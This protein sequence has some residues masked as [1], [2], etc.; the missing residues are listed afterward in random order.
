MH[1]SALLLPFFALFTAAA[2]GRAADCLLAVNQRS[3]V[4]HADLN[5]QTPVARSEGGMP[6]GNGRMGSLVWTTPKELEFQIN[7][8]DV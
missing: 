1:R 2:T 6:V 3:L 7:R 5:R 4:S 8:V